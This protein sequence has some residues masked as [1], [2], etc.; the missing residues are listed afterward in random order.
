MVSV[1][2]SRQSGEV[3][4]SQD[5]LIANACQDPSEVKASQDPSEAEDRQEPSDEVNASQIRGSSHHLSGTDM[6]C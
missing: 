2:H 3:K 1:T 5:P 4:A 6:S